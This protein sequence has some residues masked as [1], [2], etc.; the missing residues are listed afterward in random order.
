MSLEETCFV[1]C[2]KRTGAGSQNRN[3]LLDFLDI[4][5]ARLEIDLPENKRSQLGV[6]RTLRFA[7]LHTCLIAT[8]SPVDL[9][10]A[11]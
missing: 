8:I 9:S 3:L 2:N 1:L 4:I 11:L 10:I 7:W 5:F 6:C